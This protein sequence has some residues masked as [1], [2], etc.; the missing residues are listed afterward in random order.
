MKLRGVDADVADLLDAVGELHV[1]RVAVDD[2]HHRALDG[3]GRHGACRQER[4][5]Q[6]QEMPAPAQ[7]AD[8][9]SPRVDECQESETV[10]VGSERGESYWTRNMA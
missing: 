6:Q 8:T 5:E 4:Q 1:D 9:V 2:A 10:V 7:H 3:S